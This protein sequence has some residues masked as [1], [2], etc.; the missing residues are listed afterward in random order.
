MTSS[1]FRPCSKPLYPATDLFLRRVTQMRYLT[2][3][4]HG[5]LLLIL[6]AGCRGEEPAQHERA[7]LPVARIRTTTVT[8]R[9]HQML[10][11]VMGSVRSVDQAVIASK[12]TGTIEEIPV[13][14]GSAV[15][16]GDLLVLISAE[17]I[18]AK[19]VQA[20]TQLEQA[21]RNL[22]RERK[23]LA[24]DAATPESV[25]SLEEMY[26][27]AQAGYEQ[28]KTMLGYTRITAPFAGLVTAKIAN[29]GDLATPGQPLLHIENSSRL[30]V[31][32]S[33]P[34][35]LVLGM[36][37]GQQLPVFVPAAGLK[38]E[39][40]VAEIAP[41]ADPQ[42]RTAT[43]KLDIPFMPQLRSGQFA[44]VT[45]PNATR[46]SI[47]VPAEAVISF[48]QMEKVFVIRDNQAHLRFVRTGATH[49]DHI[50]ILAGLEPGEEIAVT[51]TSELIDRQ[52][53]DIIQ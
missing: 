34:E 2:P 11:E 9:P 15:K 30:Q 24:K 35:T 21:R 4:V 52:P 36:Q 48:G 17:E 23:L 6:L 33:V 31:E 39:A 29:V 41:R 14:L 10:T 16:A 1:I 51:D 50:E 37:Q 45:L 19:A 42:T 5:L 3:L 26:R 38:L 25:K 40:T 27:V 13:V 22:E 8:A 32:A 44:R 28:A 43:V 18:S 7:V 47:Y 49:D 53:V 20:K 12:I 46:E